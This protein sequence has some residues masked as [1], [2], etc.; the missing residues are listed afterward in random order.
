[1]KRFTLR[2]LIVGA[3][4]GVLTLSLGL[5][6]PDF[7][8]GFLTSHAQSSSDSKFFVFD[9]HMHPTSTAYRQGGHIG[10]PG[11]D[12][13]FTLSLARQGGLG[14][15]FFNTSIDEFHEVNHLAVKEAVKQ[16]DHFYRQIAM[17]PDQV[18]VATTAEEVRA[19]R[20]E[21]KIA[22]ILSIEGAIAIESDLG[23]L[24]MLHRLGLREMNLVHN[25]ENNIGDV[26][27]T[28]KNDGKGSGLTAYGRELVAEMNRLGILID[29]SHTADQTIF[30]VMAASTQ[31]VVTTHSGVRTLV[32]R[33]GNWSDEMIQTLARKNGVICV[34]FLPQQVSREYD[35]KW[36]GGRQR[37]SGI[38]GLEPLV[39]RGDPTKIYDFIAERTSGGGSRQAE[40]TRQRRRDMP[41]L[42]NLI[43]GIDY[44]VRLVGVDHVGISSDWGGYSVNI[45]GIENA[46]EYQNIAQALLGR[47]YSRQDVA[48]I[49][50]ENLLRVF[51]EVVTTARN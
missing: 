30:D 42:S 35:A 49:M 44:I 10:E 6:G 29:L 3:L 38:M 24:R 26:M 4:F 48:K 8:T 18:G 40:M 7:S 12:P 41:P 47:G 31:P 28:T 23:V 43:D 16:F 32:D 15:S 51:D 50:G 9:G 13:R 33:A 11:P 19:L 46:G 1:M 37:G 25:L 39:Y 2:L 14:A 20:K 5:L 27:Y 36:H 21:R 22:A 34:A 17:F 45:K